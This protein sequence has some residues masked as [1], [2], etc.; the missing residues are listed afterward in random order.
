MSTSYLLVLLGLAVLAC[1]IGALFW[2]L[3]DGKYDDSERSASDEENGDIPDLLA[4]GD[5]PP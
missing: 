3:D 2:A 1:A 5:T 4:K